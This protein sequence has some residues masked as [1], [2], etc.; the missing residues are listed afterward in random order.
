M[1]VAVSD[2][3]W[4]RQRFLQ[5][6][7]AKT[8]LLKE[9][10]TSA[11]STHSTSTSIS[12]YSYGISEFTMAGKV[13]RTRTGSGGLGLMRICFTMKFMIA[14]LLPSKAFGAVLASS[15]KTEI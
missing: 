15:A 12:P 4:A 7:R 9:G 10:G 2:S 14:S 5:T 11:L 1:S 13:E 6:L 8:L 3:A